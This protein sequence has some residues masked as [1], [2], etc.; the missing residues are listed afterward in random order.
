MQNLPRQANAS[1]PH[2]AVPRTTAN[3]RRRDTLR[4]WTSSTLAG[5]LLSTGLLTTAQ[6]AVE[7]RTSSF[8]YDTTTGLLKKEVIEPG[9][10]TLCLV[11]EYGYD[12]FGNKTSI[13][14]RNCNGTGANGVTGSPAEAA[15]PTGNAVIVTRTSTVSYNT[16]G[17]VDDVN[18]RFPLVVKNALLQPETREF[19][20]RFGTLSKVTDANG[21]IN[22]ST[23][24][25]FGRPWTTTGPYTASVAS[26]ETTTTT[27]GLCTTDPDCPSYASYWVKV[28]K[29]GA[30]AVTAYVDNIG[31]QVRTKTLGVDG[32][33]AI[34]ADT[35]YDAKGRLSQTSR[36]YFR[37]GTVYWTVND[38][39]TDPLNRVQ[40]V[41]EPASGSG[42]DA[43]TPAITWYAYNGLTTTIT[44]ENAVNNQVTIQ[45]KNSQGQLVSVQDAMS[46][47][48][49]IV[50]TISYQY[51]PF[52]NLTATIDPLGNVSVLKYDKRGRKIAMNDPD[53]GYWT[54]EYN[55]LGELRKQTDA[56]MHVT[57][58]SYDVLGRIEERAEP[59]LVTRWTYDTAKDAAGVINGVG[60][61]AKVTTDNGLQDTYTY[62]SKGRLS[63]DSRVVGTTNKSTN[64]WTFSGGAITGSF[65]N[66]YDNDGRIELKTTNLSGEL[67]V[68]KYTYQGGYLI[69][70]ADNATAQIY[71]TLNTLTADGQIKQAT[72]KNGVVE[73]RGFD[74]LGRTIS[75]TDS[76]GATSVVGLSYQ[77]D[78][79][80]NLKKRTDTP[81]NI[82]EDYTY[83]VLNRLKTVVSSNASQLTKTIEYDDIGNIISKSDTGTYSYTS[84][85]FNGTNRP[86]AVYGISST[87]ANGM[88]T[89]YSYDENGNVLSGGD[90]SYVYTSFNLP[91]QITQGGNVV[92]LMYGPDHERARETEENG[93]ITYNYHPRLDS[94]LHAD[95]RQKSGAEEFV[96]YIYAG[97]RP[98]GI[99]TRTITPQAAPYA[100]I[101]TNTMRYFHMDGQGS[102]VAIS[103]EAGG[104]QERLSYD[105]W[106]KRRN[107]VGT[108]DTTNAL[109]ANITDHGYTGHEHL[110][111]VALIHMNGRVYDPR[112]GRFLQADPTIQA[113]GN[114]QSF[115]RYTYVQNNPFFYTDPSGYSW[116]GE[117]WHALTGTD[118]AD[119]RDQ[120][121][122]PIVAI[123]ISAYMPSFGQGFWAA[124]GKAAATGFVN[125]AIIGGNIQSA[126]AGAKSGAITGGLMYGAGTIAPEGFG[127]VVAHG[128]AGCLSAAADGGDCQ[129]GALSGAAGSA[130]TQTNI[131][132]DTLQANVIAHAIVGGVTAELGGGKFEN[133]AT[134]AAFGYLF[135]E[136]S[137]ASFNRKTGALYVRDG[138]TG[139]EARGQFFSGTGSGDQIAAGDYAILQRGDKD[140]F[141]LE[142][143]DSVFGNDRNDVSG[144]S[145]LRL[146]GPGRSNGCVTAC[147]ASGWA[148]VKA[149]ITNTST[150]QVEV[151]R[152][153]SITLP[154]GYLLGRIP[155]GTEK[156]NYYGR[157][158]VE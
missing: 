120:Y 153:R 142:P 17:G 86:H 4:Q 135:N 7:I 113:P 30:P 37:G 40:K 106:G 60:K 102:I 129:S 78:R 42:P 111:D 157:L 74:N 9:D 35:K 51:D 112:T 11:T 97:N 95:Y 154:G 116:L 139:A 55:A 20:P 132:F 61:I 137:H 105:A 80:G 46:V 41:T 12:A 59:D 107:V 8:D 79:L 19:D 88:N 147:D 26:T 119:S 90:R 58:T 149:L 100:P 23:V 18:G 81:N 152:Y 126:V 72:L 124:V 145:L 14:T 24:D 13:T 6:A 93:T 103:D 32:T 75:I 52:G 77:Y 63:G 25:T 73:T 138:D 125:G 39:G 34:F 21:V 83:D 10:S 91:S 127:N 130:W 31:R 2:Q 27:Q 45:T 114:L 122:K 108:D 158:K 118:W 133:G 70:V 16:N 109:K 150:T 64:P 28:E 104:V 84:Y 123:A 148:Q 140:G 82:I 87:V 68:Q 99:H 44:R 155:V 121:V 128:V 94:G 65:S 115:N 29:S 101:V 56:A 33:T 117:R 1:A 136:L 22:A 38:Y 69:N 110:D 71:W 143:Y 53:M 48:N 85:R 98:V 66:T 57:T 96:F 5:L 141:R 43:A 62:D 156:V 67:L 76:K 54:Y 3:R 151:T 15:A 36:P 92:N 89:T 49:G 50:K 131:K 47:K 144:Q 134:T 146:H